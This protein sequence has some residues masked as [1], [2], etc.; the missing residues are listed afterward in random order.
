[1]INFL[2]FIL[3]IVL[4][5]M[6]LFLVRK[7]SDQKVR[8]RYALYIIMMILIYSVYYKFNLGINFIKYIILISSLI[9]MSIIDYKT[10]FVYSIVSYPTI[11]IGIIF[12]IYSINSHEK[13]IFSIESI[14]ALAA[15]IIILI[16][17]ALLNKFGWGDI[18]V[19]LICFLFF[20]SQILLNIIFISMLLGSFISCLKLINYKKFKG[21]QIA[22]VPYITVAVLVNLFFCI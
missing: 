3:N 6:I 5:S 20:N 8:V 4:S 2:L 13:I 16:I 18:D 21:K 9:L 11:I 17:S 12:K 1:M 22:F 19:F 15:I 7:I 14:I 10:K